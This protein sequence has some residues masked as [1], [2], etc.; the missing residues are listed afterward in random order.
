MKIN[1][2]QYM[3]LRQTAQANVDVPNANNWGQSL[4]PTRWRRCHLQMPHCQCVDVTQ[5][6]KQT[7]RLW[8][9]AQLTFTRVSCCQW[10]QTQLQTHQNVI[11]NWKGGLAECLY[12]LSPGRDKTSH[13]Y[14]TVT[15]VEGKAMKTAVSLRFLSHSVL[16]LFLI[17][18]SE[19]A[20]FL[21]SQVHYARPIIILGPVKDRIN[22]DLLSEFPDKFGSCV[23]R[24]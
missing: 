1:D 24:K 20:F 12:V 4:Y 2:A 8:T 6:A 17:T 22:D 16:F 3:E 7:R 13:S 23:P 19:C 5:T 9:K 11:Y 14:E 10:R 21:L 15:Q 18:L